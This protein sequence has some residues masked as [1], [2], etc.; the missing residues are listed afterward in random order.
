MTT[1]KITLEQIEQAVSVNCV[2]DHTN[3]KRLTLK[4]LPGP[5]KNTGI[6]RLIFIY[7]ADKLWYTG[8]EI[9]EYIGMTTEEYGTRF[10]RLPRL[11]REGREAF[12]SNPTHYDDVPLFFYR[13]LRLITNYI[14][15]THGITLFL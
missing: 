6:G 10:E 13:K 11:I 3:L 15:V 2:I 8:E 4:K 1:G 5:I 7:L 14:Y 12:E 9:R